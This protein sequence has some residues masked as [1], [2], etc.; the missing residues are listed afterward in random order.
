[1]NIT[2]FNANYNWLA[3]RQICFGWGRRS[4]V[5]ELASSLGERAFIVC[6]S[7]TLEQ[8]GQLAEIEDLLNQSGVRSVQLETVTRE[9]EVE[10]VD[11]VVEQLR[12]HQPTTSDLVIGIGGGA[13]LDLAKAV[14][15][16]ATNNQS[17]TVKDYLEGV[18]KGCQIVNEPLPM[19]AMPTTSGTGSEATKNAVISCYEPAFKKSL[20]SDNMI[21]RVVLVDPELTVSLPPKQSAES[22]MDAITQLL[23]SYLS[24]RSRPLSDALCL[25][26]I[27]LAFE[28]IVACVENGTDR[29]A[30]EK[31]AQAAMLSGMALANSGLGMAHGVAASLG[32][33]CRI[34]HGLACAVMLPV[35]L[36]TNRGCSFERMGELGRLISGSPALSN[37]EAAERLIQEVERLNVKVGIPQRLSE[38]GVEKEQLPDIVK[39]SRG[40]SMSG[41]PCELSDEQLTEILESIL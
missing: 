1:V 33:N 9:P 17:D 38:L 11:R 29:V 36:K 5:G 2:T 34:N 14:S 8:N 12:R 39:G 21:P 4:E 24:C 27:P 16:L 20:R 41:N 10:D 26:G 18:G 6:G 31:M 19:L 35:T 22:G 30:R 40:N 3:P 32:V 37:E 15:A 25:Q 13:G 23:E 28:S 7:R